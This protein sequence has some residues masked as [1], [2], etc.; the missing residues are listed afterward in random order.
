MK[1]LGNVRNFG[2]LIDQ[3]IV[4]FSTQISA[5]EPKTTSLSASF[6]KGGGGRAS[7]SGNVVTVFGATGKI[8]SAVINEL[9]KKGNQIVIPYRCDP[10]W[11]REL[12]VVGDLGQ[13]LFV[14]F[15]LKD[16]KSIADAVKYSNVVV[17][18]IGSRIETKAFNFFETHEHGARRIAKICRESGV[19]KLIHISALNSSVNPEGH[20]I[21]GGS[22][23]LRSKAHGEIAVREE[24]P[25][26]TIIKPAVMFGEVDSF[27]R[28]YVSR[29][30]KTFFDNVYLYKA[31]EHTYKMPVYQNDVAKGIRLAVMDPTVHGKT[32]EFVGPHCYKLSELIDYMYKKAHCL[33]KF[34]FNYKRHGYPDPVFI[35][36]LLASQIWSKIFKSDVPLNKEWME[37][38]EGTSDV[39]TGALTLKDLGL[40]RLTEFEYIGGMLAARYSFFNY[41]EQEYN[42]LPDPPLPLRSPPIVKEKLDVSNIVTSTSNFNV[43]A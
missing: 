21:S 24:F 15:D 28:I 2:K 36:Y 33:K 11:V 14:P 16:E 10:Y 29:F 43:Y 12:K 19:E 7:F 25:N 9:A 39:L 23:F 30:R 1:L 37:V 26:A 40:H 22:N 18:L 27:I 6:K 17:N 13:V 35:S 5:P 8:G 3:N 31:G 38:V 32:F 20:L 4:G 41:Y 34:S 42:E